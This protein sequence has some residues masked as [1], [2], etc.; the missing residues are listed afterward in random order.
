MLGAE[1]SNWLSDLRDLAGA[2]LHEQSDIYEGDLKV[3]PYWKPVE[4]SEGGR[5]QTQP[6]CWYCYHLFQ[7]I[8]FSQW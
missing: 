3:N 7:N 1:E 8:T 5:P 2:L 6:D 4:G